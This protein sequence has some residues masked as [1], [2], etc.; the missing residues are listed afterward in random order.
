ML[1]HKM[2]LIFSRGGEG[3]VLASTGEVPFLISFPSEKEKGGGGEEGKR[4]VPSLLVDSGGKKGRI[5]LELTQT[6]IWSGGNSF[7][8]NT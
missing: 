6:R 7:N 2:L 4:G 8:S 5:K 3:A 1:D